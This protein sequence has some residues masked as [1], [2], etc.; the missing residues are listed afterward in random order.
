M[1]PI[2]GYIVRHFTPADPSKP[3][4]FRDERDAL[5]RCADLNRT[6]PDERWEVKEIIARRPGFYSVLL[7]TVMNV[8]F[9][10]IEAR[11][12]E[13]AVDRIDSI[14]SGQVFCDIFPARHIYKKVSN[15][16]KSA[17]IEYIDWAEEHH[18]ALVDEE[19]GELDD[20]EGSTWLTP[21]LNGPGW[22]PSVSDPDMVTIAEIARVALDRDDVRDQIAENMDLCDKEIIRINGI[23]NE[24]LK[25]T[26]EGDKP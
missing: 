14:V 23:I 19:N 9:G 15:G 17:V 6:Q 25:D 22:M 11:S 2:K 26:E 10:L 5:G 24:I 1:A 21:R 8:R 20:F 16:E 3:Q 12:P 7:K 4:V 18:E 13:D